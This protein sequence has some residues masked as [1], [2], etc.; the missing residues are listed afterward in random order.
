[1]CRS[2]SSAE[3]WKG[4]GCAYPS[5]A[6]RFACP[7]RAI[8]TADLE[9]ERDQTTGRSK[10]GRSKPRPRGVPNLLTDVGRR[11]ADAAA[12]ND[13]MQ[14]IAAAIQEGAQAYLRR[15][16]T[17]IGMVVGRGDPGRMVFFLIGWR[18]RSAS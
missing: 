18:E 12:G 8:G 9:D 14:E 16:Y 13:K 15:Q 17:T 2:R 6:E 4:R 3:W 7:R 5:R 11:R 1:M 10:S